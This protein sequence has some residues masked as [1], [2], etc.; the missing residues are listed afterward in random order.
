MIGEGGPQERTLAGPSASPFRESRGHARNTHGAPATPLGLS[1]YSLFRA[2]EFL[3]Y[4]LARKGCFET[5]HP[6][7]VF[8][9]FVPGFS[10]FRAVRSGDE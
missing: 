9:L 5:P 1:L 8:S 6:V 4:A 3:A 2:P 10:L 7:P